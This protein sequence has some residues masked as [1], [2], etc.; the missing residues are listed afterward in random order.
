MV[1]GIPMLLQ[2][3]SDLIELTHEVH[4]ELTGR[5]MTTHKFTDMGDDSCDKG[6]LDC[7]SRAG[8][9][10]VIL[11]RPAESKAPAPRTKLATPRVEQLASIH[12]T[13]L[14]MTQA[15]YDLCAS[16]ECFAPF[17]DEVT[18]VLLRRG[19]WSKPVL[20]YFLKLDSLL[21]ES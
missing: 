8:C 10:V 19:G 7:D 13:A 21:K 6:Y 15:L 14:T 16:P 12:T 20:N 11:F 1:N 3:A 17:W 9:A 2:A 5:R 18:E 4:A